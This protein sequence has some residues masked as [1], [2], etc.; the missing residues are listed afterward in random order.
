MIYPMFAMVL[1]TFGVLLFAFA[2]RVRAVR[3]KAV[4]ISY[5]RT[6]QGG[7]VPAHL[8]ASTRH[9]A[10]LFEMPVLFYAVCLLAMVLRTESPLLPVL[11]WLYVAL[12]VVHTVIHL[13]Y[14]NV[15]HRMLAFFLS[16]TVLLVMWLVV[17]VNAQQV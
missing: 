17:V 5:F 12:R 9:F 4:K 6:M 7:E 3:S 16:C 8:V 15:M 13:G 11:A 10:N 2:Q 14:N 1:L